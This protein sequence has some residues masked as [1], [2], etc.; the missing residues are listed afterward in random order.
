M[1]VPSPAVRPPPMLQTWIECRSLHLQ[2]SP[3]EL[4]DFCIDRKI[5]YVINKDAIFPD[6][7][8]TEVVQIGLGALKHM[9]C[10]GIKNIWGQKWFRR[11]IMG[12]GQE[13]CQNYWGPWP[14][15]SLSRPHTLKMWPVLGH[16]K[17]VQN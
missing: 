16:R 11:P 2:K 14:Q 9:G 6:V 10:H 4:C 12:A 5:K 8:L 15:V 17:S 13:L 7:L 1:H 3:I